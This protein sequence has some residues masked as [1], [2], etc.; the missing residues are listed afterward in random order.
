M[1][2][3]A[4]KN[5]VQQRLQ[6]LTQYSSLQEPCMAYPVLSTELRGLHWHVQ[7]RNPQNAR[8]SPPIGPKFRVAKFIYL[9]TACR[10]RFSDTVNFLSSALGELRIHKRA[11][12]NIISPETP[13]QKVNSGYVNNK[14]FTNGESSSW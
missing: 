5:S 2:D 7:S 12:V 1:S 9:N 13:K 14:N 6:P 11:L 10:G 3:K 4:W 8:K